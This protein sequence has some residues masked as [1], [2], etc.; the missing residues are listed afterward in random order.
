MRG[1]TSWIYDPTTV[2][3]KK[4]VARNIVV[5]LKEKSNARENAKH[6]TTKNISISMNK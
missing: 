4:N 1:L 6:N 5:A 2:Y 3:A